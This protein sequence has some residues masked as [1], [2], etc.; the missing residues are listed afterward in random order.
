MP[1]VPGVT[2]QAIILGT[3]SIDGKTNNV[4]HLI[5]LKEGKV[6]E[7]IAWLENFSTVPEDKFIVF[8]HKHRKLQTLPI[9]KVQEEIQA[10]LDKIGATFT[11]RTD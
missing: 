8:S 1:G 3:W 9:R 5:V 6:L 4:K 10:R 7:M 2:L 11:M